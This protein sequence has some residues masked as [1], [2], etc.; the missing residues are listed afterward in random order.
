MEA[1]IK[2]LWYEYNLFRA[3]I[4]AALRISEGFKRFLERKVKEAEGRLKDVITAFLSD[5]IYWVELLKEELIPVMLI[6][7]K[8]VGIVTKS[9]EEGW[10]KDSTTIF[11]LL[12][13]IRAMKEKARKICLCALGKELFERIERFARDLLKNPERIEEREEEI[14]ELIDELKE[15]DEMFD[16]HL[17][18]LRR[19]VKRKR[20]VLEGEVV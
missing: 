14:S 12:K 7:G 18:E 4:I 19:R 8:R 10:I 16:E 6:V 9:L 2:R 20:M 3:F 13:L 1:H 15:L 17:K 11:K 5:V